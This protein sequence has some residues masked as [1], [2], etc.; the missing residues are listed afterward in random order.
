MEHA[1]CSKVYRMRTKCGGIES[2]L[3]ALQ[4]MTSK[5]YS[6]SSKGLM[7]IFSCK[8][9]LEAP[10]KAIPRSQ[11]DIND[12]YISWF[13]LS[14]LKQLMVKFFF[15]IQEKGL[16][17]FSLKLNISFAAWHIDIY[18]ANKMRNHTCTKQSPICEI[19]SG[20]KWGFGASSS[21]TKSSLEDN[22][23]VD[24]IAKIAGDHSKKE[25]GLIF[26][27]AN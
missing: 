21:Q 23:R 10:A 27:P 15:L 2:L 14:R 1:P 17:L 9:G 22:T 5:N 7:S 18:V 19:R 6:L 11:S 16:E 12:K 13:C 3:F 25:T 4:L 26:S 20:V 24:N 8:K